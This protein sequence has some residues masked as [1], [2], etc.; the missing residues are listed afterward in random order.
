M[1]GTIGSMLAATL[2]TLLV[3]GTAAQAAGKDPA[4]GTAGL[5]IDTAEMNAGRLLIAGT[6]AKAGQ[7]VKID[8]RTNEAT[9]DKTGAFRFSLRWRPDDC[10]VKLVAGTQQQRVLVGGCGPTGETGKTGPTGAAGARGA[11]GA[12]GAQG[13]QGPVGATGATGPTGAAGAAGATGAAGPDGP[14]IGTINYIGIPLTA[15]TG[16]NAWQFL[17]TDNTPSSGA[18]GYGR[19]TG[20][21]SAS[22]GTTGAAF[23]YELTFCYQLN[24]GGAITPFLDRDTAV[25][26]TTPS[27]AS[28]QAVAAAAT[29]TTFSSSEVYKVGMC[30]YLEAGENLDT[31]LR[32]SYSVVLSE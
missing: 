32:Q 24:S 31:G 3:A 19:F 6:A 9:A 23:Q 12:K 4:A 20:F 27:S 8:G 29:T 11:Q 26:V 10:V 28:F 30:A 22:L 15:I 14:I 25:Q 13:A 18:T 16:A 2:A 5:T 7:V 21:G 17:S 1:T